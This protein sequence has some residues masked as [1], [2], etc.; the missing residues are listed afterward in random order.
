M[1]VRL[2]T[3]IPQIEDIEANNVF[4]VCLVDPK[5]TSIPLTIS[6]RKA[7]DR[8]FQIKYSTHLCIPAQLQDIK[9]WKTK[10][11]M[12]YVGFFRLSTLMVCL[13]LASWCTGISDPWRL[14]TMMDLGVIQKIYTISAQISYRYFPMS[15]VHWKLEQSWIKFF[16]WRRK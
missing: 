7:R 8:N 9:V 6:I 4:Q 13:I 3:H 16:Q 1:N 5:S 15:V 12:I 14:I 10:S 2:W 11:F